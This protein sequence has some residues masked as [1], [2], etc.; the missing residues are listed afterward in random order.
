MIDSDYGVNCQNISSSNLILDLHFNIGQPDWIMANL[1]SIIAQRMRT[2]SYEETFLIP[3]IPGRV[4]SDKYDKELMRAMR[5]LLHVNPSGAE[6]G[7]FRETKATHGCW[8]T[9]SL[10]ARSSTTMALS[11]TDQVG[12]LSLTRKVTLKVFAPSQ[13]FWNDRQF[14]CMFMFHQNNSARKGR[15]FLF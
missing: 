14:K 4:A 3:D 7:I 15:S 12:S 13:V 11:T 2:G 1:S 5:R 6:A 8:C 9:G 10:P